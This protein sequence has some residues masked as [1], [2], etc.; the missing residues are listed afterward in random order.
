MARKIT[1]FR[2][3][4]AFSAGL[5]IASA[6]AAS[7]APTQANVPEASSNKETVLTI[8]NTSLFKSSVIDIQKPAFIFSLKNDLTGNYDLMISSFGLFSA[9]K[10]FK[11]EDIATQVNSDSYNIQ[12]ALNKVVWP[13]EVKKAP[14]EIFGPGFYSSAG[15][16]LVPGKQTGA[17]TVFNPDKNVF[18]EISTPKKGFFYHRILW[19]D[20]NGDGHIDGITA[21]ANKPII[22]RSKGELLW[23][24][25]PGSNHLE[26]W[27][28]H[29]INDSSDVH[30]RL[31]DIN[32]DGLLDIISTNFFSKKLTITYQ[33]EGPTWSSQVIDADLG[34][35]FDLSVVD[36]NGDGNKDLLVTNHEADAKAAVFAYDMISSDPASWVRHT[37]HEGFVTKQKGI[38]SASP[39]EAIAFHPQVNAPFAKPW[40]VVAGDGSQKAHLLIPRSM[41]SQNWEY[42]EKVIIDTGS[43][44]GKISAKDIDG[45]GYTNIF[46]P[47]YDK[48][49]IHVFEFGPAE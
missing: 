1:F 37:L 45:D 34:S 14:A 10:I 23:L 31:L 2:R 41:D 42:D 33:L 11:I 17:I 26:R 43:T 13:N 48:D 6:A 18:A 44:V 25:N 7:Q 36:I 28:E 4:A 9:D 47:A 21:R 29:V 22:G 19:M 32:S 5:G 20:I 27:K 8:D 15:G 35:A 38:G 3:L 46:V 39:G 16:F 49:Q 40:I 24:E 12:T 30:F